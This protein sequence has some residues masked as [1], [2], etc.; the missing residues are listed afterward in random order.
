M[1]LCFRRSSDTALRKAHTG[2]KWDCVDE[3]QR[4][5]SLIFEFGVKERDREREKKRER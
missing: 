4:S 1:V 3:V 2:M 5:L